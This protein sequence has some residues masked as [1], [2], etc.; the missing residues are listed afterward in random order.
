MTVPEKKKTSEN[1][2]ELSKTYEIYIGKHVDI[3]YVLMYCHANVIWLCQMYPS[4]SFLI[5]D[6]IVLESKIK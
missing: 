3:V 4:E 5:V 2:R 6:I 1:N